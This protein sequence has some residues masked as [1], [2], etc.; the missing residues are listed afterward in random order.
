MP[1]WP[2]AS[3]LADSQRFQPFS[4]QRHAALCHSASLQRDDHSDHLPTFQFA[5]LHAFS[6]LDRALPYMCS[7]HDCTCHARY[8]ILLDH[9]HFRARDHCFKSF[10]LPPSEGLWQRIRARRFTAT[11]AGF[12]HCLRFL[13]QVFV[14][15]QTFTKIRPIPDY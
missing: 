7:N 1:F 3:F 5:S 6:A 4:E 2:Y 13:V 11:R 9:R 15:L 14:K 10:R 8:S 12:S